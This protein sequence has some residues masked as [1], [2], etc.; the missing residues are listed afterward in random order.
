ML[1]Y[2]P[3]FT[4]LIGVRSQEKGKERAEQSRA[5]HVQVLQHSILLLC[6]GEAIGAMSQYADKAQHYERYLCDGQQS[7]SSP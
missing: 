5:G 6:K 7:P 2:L 3:F 4:L 1:L